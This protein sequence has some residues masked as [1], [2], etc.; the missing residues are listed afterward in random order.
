M[1]VNIENGTVKFV[2]FVDFFCNELYE[3]YKPSQ[4]FCVT[5]ALNAKINKMGEF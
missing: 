2:E 4:F 1:V 5:M 3:C